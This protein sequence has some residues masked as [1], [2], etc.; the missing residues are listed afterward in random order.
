MHKLLKVL[1]ISLLFFAACS[2]KVEPIRIGKDQCHYC[3]M[4]ISDPKFG[5][6]WVT[7]KGKVFKFDAL[8][9]TVNYLNDDNTPE[10]EYAFTTAIAFDTPGELHHVKQLHFLISPNLPSPMGANLSAYTNVELAKKMQEEHQGEIYDWES[11]RK[12][13]NSNY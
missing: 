4:I 3:K 6:E 13:L 8:E 9:C 2:P 10:Q 12:Q 7:S 11:L 1:F 5:S